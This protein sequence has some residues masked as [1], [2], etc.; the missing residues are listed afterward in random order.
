MAPE[1][2]R[3]SAWQAAL[4]VAAAVV[5]AAL[6]V[7]V[8]VELGAVAASLQQNRALGQGLAEERIT[9]LAAI[10]ASMAAKRGMARRAG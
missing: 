5:L 8:K 2:G 6:H 1:V 9:L 10:E 4:L 7:W 3:G